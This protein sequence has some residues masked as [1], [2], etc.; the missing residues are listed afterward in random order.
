[1]S[2]VGTLALSVYTAH[3]VVLWALLAVAPQATRGVDVWLLFACGAIVAATGWR[4]ILGRGP[5]ERLLTW[6]S[7]RAA[8]VPPSSPSR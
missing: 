3:I 4:S 1:L 6:S 5:L 7:G 2:A 8:A